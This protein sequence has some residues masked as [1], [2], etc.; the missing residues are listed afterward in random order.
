MN[1]LDKYH[2]EQQLIE[3][4]KEKTGHGCVRTLRSWRQRRLGPPWLKFGKTILYPDDGFE[5]WL[6]SQVQEPARSPSPRKR[7]ISQHPTA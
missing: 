3:R 1:A 5:A 7:A 4:L 2:T 6:R